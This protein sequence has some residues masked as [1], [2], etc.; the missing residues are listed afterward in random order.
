M[1]C[2]VIFLLQDILALI[3]SRVIFFS[4]RKPL[5][6]NASYENAQ[7]NND[8]FHFLQCAPHTKR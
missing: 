3:H 7:Y 5:K 8:S 1:N 6:F 2:Y 4:Y